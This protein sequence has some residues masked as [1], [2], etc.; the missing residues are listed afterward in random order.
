MVVG[1]IGGAPPLHVESRPGRGIDVVAHGRVLM[2]GEPARYYEGIQIE[3]DFAAA[4]ELAHDF[5]LPPITATDLRDAPQAE[6]EWLRHWCRWTAERI[7]QH[8]FGYASDWGVQIARLGARPIDDRWEQFGPLVCN[9]EHTLDEPASIYKSWMLVGS[10]HCLAL[11]ERPSE[12]EG[13]VKY[14][15]K[16]ARSGRMPPIVV[17]W[18]SGFDCWVLIDGHRRLLAAQLE[19]R[20]PQ[21]IAVHS[22]VEVNWPITME[23]LARHDR[24]R[25]AR[26]R[27]GTLTAEAIRRLD[28]RLI[29]IHD[30]R[31]CWRPRTRAWYRP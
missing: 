2:H 6:R 1:D 25:E 7:G 23:A 10:G 15:R 19:D 21:V 13:R 16:Q 11:R 5:P 18:I 4:A 14:W 31:P 30:D 3:R 28:Q 20:L 26:E 24:E 17:W 22:F 12:H 8:N 9:L 27:N 29:Q